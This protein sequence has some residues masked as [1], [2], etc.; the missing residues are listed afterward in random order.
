MALSTQVRRN[1]IPAPSRVELRPRRLNLALMIAD[2]HLVGRGD[3]TA[4][5]LLVLDALNFCF[6]PEEG[7]SYEHLATG[8][9]V[10]I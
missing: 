5:Y 8:L 3:L 9:K 4:Q 2:I 10:T 6:W 7:L 1:L